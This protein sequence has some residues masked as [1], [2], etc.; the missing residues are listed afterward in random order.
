[1]LQISLWTATKEEIKTKS[2]LN[3]LMQA[4][5]QDESQVKI[6]IRVNKLIGAHE[7]LPHVL[8]QEVAE[9]NYITTQ[10]SQV[11]I[12]IRVNKPIG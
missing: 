4:I 2:K 9:E 8:D 11:E 10:K 3:N 12:H 5:L 1:M 6:H 7:L